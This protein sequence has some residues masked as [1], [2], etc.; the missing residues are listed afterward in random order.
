MI[1]QQM[2]SYGTLYFIKKDAQAHNDVVGFDVI[3]RWTISKLCPL[4]N[5]Y[6]RC[7]IKVTGKNHVP[8][9]WLCEKI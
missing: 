5:W 7:P 9:G 2:V 4:V 8:K 1:P 3:I 6:P